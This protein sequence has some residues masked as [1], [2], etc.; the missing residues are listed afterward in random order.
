[1][2]TR[3]FSPLVDGAVGDSDRTLVRTER[4][5]G[6]GLI[7]REICAIQP[8]PG[9]MEILIHPGFKIFSANTALARQEAIEPQ[10]FESGTTRTF[11]DD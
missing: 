3:G 1:L 4:V 7:M 8:R 6:T 5:V 11:S 9:S 10:A 2:I